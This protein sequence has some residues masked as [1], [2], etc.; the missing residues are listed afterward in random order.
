MADIN[1][2]LKDYSMLYIDCDR[3][4][5]AELSEYFS[6]FVPGYRYMP[7]F[8]RKVWDGKIRLFNRITGEL[9][10][11]LY[12]YLLKF[13]KEC[14]YTM[15]T[16]ETEYGFPMAIDQSITGDKLQ[17]FY[18]ALKLPFDL[19]DYQHDAVTVALQRKRA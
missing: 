1:V 7:A 6:F 13:C 14:G 18:K 4:I 16:E 5:S 10:A 9:N 15:D 8:K 2:K 12:I 19:R 11:G 3:G 17:D